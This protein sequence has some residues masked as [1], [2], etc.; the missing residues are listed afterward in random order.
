[1][2]KYL[3]RSIPLL[4]PTLPFD[5]SP[6]VS[7]ISSPSTYLLYVFQEFDEPLRNHARHTFLDRPIKYL[8]NVRIFFFRSF[9]TR[10]C[11]FPFSSSRLLAR[12]QSFSMQ[13]GRF[14][15]FN[16]RASTRAVPNRGRGREREKERILASS[17]FIGHGLLLDGTLLPSVPFTLR[18]NPL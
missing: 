9:S 12:W 1:M 11:I 3:C 18:P 13:A 10:S 8:F 2:E 15:R 4:T 5:F 14:K 16:N 6:Y 7:S 17:T